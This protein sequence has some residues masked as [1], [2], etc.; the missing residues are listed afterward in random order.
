MPRMLGDAALIRLSFKK[1]V[2][3]EYTLVDADDYERVST[4]KWSARQ[5]GK[6]RYAV[7]TSFNHVPQ[8]LG[9]LHRYIM[10]A[11]PGQIVDHING[12]TLDNR[13]QNLRIV[14]PQQSA[15]NTRRQTF[16][17]KTS[18]FKGVS[19]DRT[20]GRWL[21]GITFKGERHDIGRFDVEEDAAR[22]YDKAA[23][24]CFEQHARTNE[25]MRLFE[26]E[27]PF[28]PD[29]ANTATPDGAVAHADLASHTGFYFGRM[30][31]GQGNRQRHEFRRL[32]HYVQS[33]YGAD[34]EPVA[35]VMARVSRHA[36]RRELRHIYAK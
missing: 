2:G 5:N 33:V 25:V 36:K 12:D 19:W 4:T 32:Q 24:I 11:K 15:A 20:T 17:G 1:H 7:A 35:T 10:W 30:F 27:D 6:S 22:A 13:K 18:R 31:S 29:A 21:A 14:T 23:L 26:M 9:S 28:V 34:F 8:R 3:T 16:P